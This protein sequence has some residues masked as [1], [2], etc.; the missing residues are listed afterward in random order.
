MEKK[1]NVSKLILTDSV[2]QVDNS[3]EPGHGHEKQKQVGGS[4]Q[5]F[6]L[7]DLSRRGDRQR[8][9]EDEIGGNWDG[10]EIHGRFGEKEAAENL[11]SLID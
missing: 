7:V 1:K 3:V 5:E 11:G 9:K 10:E 2:A 4:D 8:N 6:G